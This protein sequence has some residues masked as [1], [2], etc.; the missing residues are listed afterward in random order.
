MN[1]PSGPHG[2]YDG[3]VKELAARHLG[4]IK[5][6]FFLLLVSLPGALFFVSAS[7][8]GYL[9]VNRKYAAVDTLYGF[10]PGD[11]K[12]EWIR[13][14]IYDSSRDAIVGAHFLGFPL[15]PWYVRWYKEIE[16]A[17]EVLAFGFAL[18][19]LTLLAYRFQRLA[20]LLSPHLTFYFIV[21]SLVPVL[22]LLVAFF[23]LRSALD[24]MRRIGLRVG[25]LGI[26][27]EHSADDDP[28]KELAARHLGL[29]KAVLFI[30]LISLPAL[31]GMG[32][33]AK[34]DSMFGFVIFASLFIYGVGNLF[35]RFFRLTKLLYPHLAFYSII[36][37][38]LPLMNVIV[39]LLLLWSALR[40][41]RQRGLSVGFFGIDPARFG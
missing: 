16:T 39:I 29:V 20:G 18:L 5:A 9:E 36:L 14:H 2:F 30:F 24:Q 11:V 41:M 28:L 13:P 6:I 4:L 27:A 31:G 32:M 40:R 33:A 38:L 35:Y 25:V 23:L 3:P 1:E 34:K 15:G 12:R 37:G 19:G 8:A 17:C 10:T 7:E 22:N 26:D 21:M